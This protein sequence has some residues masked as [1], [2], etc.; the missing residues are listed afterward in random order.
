MTD[1]LTVDWD[2]VKKE[3]SRKERITS[4]S[5]DIVRA[6]LE[7]SLK[8]AILLAE[9]RAISVVKKV[10]AT[11][12]HYIETDGDHRF[13]GKGLSS[14][15][16]SATHIGIFLVTIGERLETASSAFMA[17]GKELTGYLLD[18][19][20]SMAVESLAVNMEESFRR[21]YAAL[22]QSVSVRLSPGYC[23]WK[24]EEQLILDKILDFSK[25]GVRLTKSCMMIPK[26]SISA[27]VGLAPEKVFGNRKSSSCAICSMGDCNYRRTY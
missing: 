24:L 23:D 11:G 9:P 18:R 27:I 1:N 14:Q 17:G 21:S 6:S 8:E 26:K 16:K 2:W 20:G 15:L 22:K 10:T 19:I 25:A 7:E 12:S 13:T 3:V 4:S 5:Y